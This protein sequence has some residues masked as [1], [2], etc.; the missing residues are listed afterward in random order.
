MNTLHLVLKKQWFEEI[1]LGRKTEEYRDLSNFWIHRL[2]SAR[3]HGDCTNSDRGKEG[4]CAYCHASSP[5]DWT[6]F[7]FDHVEFQLGYAKDALRMTFEVKEICIGHGDTFYGAPRGIRPH[8]II[9]LGMRIDVAC[10]ITPADLKAL[11]CGECDGSCY[12]NNG[13]PYVEEAAL[14]WNYGDR[15]DE[16]GC[17]QCFKKLKNLK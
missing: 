16:K 4:V 5:N 17:F 6:A 2:C 12:S 11:G 15:S 1:A 8:F 7:S 9:K 10:V 13:K 14:A 3:I